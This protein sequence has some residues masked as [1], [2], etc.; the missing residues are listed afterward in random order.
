M[1]KSLQQRLVNYK[2]KLK[3]GCSKVTIVTKQEQILGEGRKNYE[4]G[5]LVLAHLRKE[6]FSKG[7]YNKLK[8]KKNGPCRILR[9]FSA[10]AYELENTTRIGIS[11]I[12]NVADLYTYVADD[13]GQ[14][15]EDKDTVE[16][17]QWL[18]QMPIAQPSEAK[19]ILDTRVAKSTRQRYYLE[20]LVKWKGHPVEDSTWMNDQELETKSF[21]IADLLNRGLEF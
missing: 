14:M 20:Y 8:M 12:F 2:S 18:K 1:E 15:T 17:L 5:D 3:Q 19:Y 7:E 4:V 21:S 16:D 13:T 10:N 11:P 6:I 9:K